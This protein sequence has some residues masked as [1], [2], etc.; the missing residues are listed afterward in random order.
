[1]TAQAEYSFSIPVS[2][3]Q[4]L[5][6]SLLLPL[7]LILVIYGARI[8]LFTFD[9]RRKTR[10]HFLA[11]RELVPPPGGTHSH[12]A[13]R[14]RVSCAKQAIKPEYITQAALTSIYPPELKN[15]T[16][17]GTPLDTPG[18]SV[19]QFFPHSKRRHVSIY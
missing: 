18:F 12:F 3:C 10:I 2:L 16:P 9:V 1:M 5:V 7:Y 15:G 11:P 14:R 17:Q 8:H 19:P 13:T 6:H 4:H